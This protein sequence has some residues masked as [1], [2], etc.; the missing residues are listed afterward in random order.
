MSTNPTP[1]NDR[2]VGPT[3]GT[4]AHPDPVGPTDPGSPA[5]GSATAAARAREDRSARIAVTV[6]PAIIIAAALLGF[7]APPVGLALAPWVSVFLGVIMFGMGLTLTLPDFALVARRPLPVLIG[8]LAQFV[9]MPLVGLGVALLLQLPPELA[10]G[11]ILVGC[12][13]GGTSSNVISYLA[14]ADT[15]LSVTMTSISTLLAPLFTPLLTVWLAGTYMPVDAAAMAMSIVKMVLVPVV[16]GLLIR[17]LAPRLV[18]R[19]LPALPWISV[20]GISLVVVAVVA[21]SADT[22]VSAGLI[23]FAA[24][25]LHNAAGYLLGYGTA[26]LAQ[27]SEAASRTTSVEVGMQNSGLAATLAAQY[28]NPAAAL[29]AAVFSIWHNISGAILAMIYRR[30]ADRSGC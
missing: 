9:I 17:L 2:P 23:V 30:S 15:A 16:G 26:K 24:V 28:M 29:P 10:A 22:V 4:T 18:D 8:V 5:S 12:A 11:V 27:Q 20:A 14:K 21:G 25:V 3:G 13:P 7:V 1:N 19:I 6:F